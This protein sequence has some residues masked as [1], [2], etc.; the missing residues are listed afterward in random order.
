MYSINIQNKKIFAYKMS[1]LSSSKISSLLS[2]LVP[3]TE[4]Y[5]FFFFRFF[6]IFKHLLM[7]STQPLEHY[8]TQSWND[9]SHKL[10]CN[11]HKTT[12]ATTMN[13]NNPKQN[14]LEINILCSF[15]SLLAFLFS[16]YF[17]STFTVFDWF[18]TFSVEN[19]HMVILQKAIAIEF[20]IWLFA[21]S[22]E[23]K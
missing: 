7:I 23:Y 9:C 2:W 13:R 10:K 1:S 18:K 17:A 20:A 22:R 12:I 4:L 6:L 8:H 21:F 3:I 19:L 11:I 16:F 15:S 5:Y 14:L